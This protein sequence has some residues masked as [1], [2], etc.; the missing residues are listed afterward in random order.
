MLGYI[1]WGGGSQKRKKK[2]LQ[3]Y[4][5]LL[6]YDRRSSSDTPRLEL[7]LLH[8]M[9]RLRSDARKKKKKKKKNTCV[10]NT[11]K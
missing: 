10:L 2:N 1:L 5:E 4:S 6:S 11:E 3:V 7:P 8:C 9:E